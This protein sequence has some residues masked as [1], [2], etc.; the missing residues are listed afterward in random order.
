MLNLQGC[1]F[2]RWLVVVKA[3]GRKWTCVCKCGTHKDVDHYALVKGLSVSCGCWRR[4]Q[5]SDRNTTHGLS[6]T[7]EYTN[8]QSMRNRCLN[9]ADKKYKRYGGRGIKIC[10]RWNSFR[11]FLQDMGL[12]P[13]LLHSLDRRDN[14][15]DYKPS[16]CKWSTPLEQARNKRTTHW[17][18]ADGKR[19]TL[20]QWAAETGIDQRKI[21]E[22]IRN[23]WTAERALGLI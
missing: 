13:T 22:R 15:G 10:K 3:E 9:P 14:N 16:N 19:Q 4:Q 1:E 7:P 6:G 21:G 20:S 23:G 17:I 2:G 5:L 8:W 18:E 12:R 11:L